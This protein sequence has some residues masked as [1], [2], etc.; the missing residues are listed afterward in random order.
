MTYNFFRLLE[1]WYLVAEYSVT[2]NILNGCQY[3]KP[4]TLSCTKSH[5]HFSLLF[6]IQFARCKFGEFGIRSTNSP[7]IDIFLYSHH[8][9]A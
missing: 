9:S 7:L 8:M 3:T 1:A 6:A 2:F 4:F 5:L